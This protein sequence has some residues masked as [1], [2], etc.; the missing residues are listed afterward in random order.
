[1]HKAAR[2]LSVIMALGLAIAPM[3]LLQGCNKYGDDENAPKVGDI[4]GPG[5]K[6]LPPEAQKIL[7]DSKKLPPEPPPFQKGPSK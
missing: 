6:A 5:G 2:A 4:R 7:D 3:A 1:M